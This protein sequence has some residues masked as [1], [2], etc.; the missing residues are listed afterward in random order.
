[1]RLNNTNFKGIGAAIAESI[2]PAVSVTQFN[3]RQGHLAQ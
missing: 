1:M 3:L 2:I